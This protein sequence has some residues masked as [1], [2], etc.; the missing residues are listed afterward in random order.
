MAYENITQ[1]VE[2]L[3]LFNS[4]NRMMTYKEINML[5]DLLTDARA[6]LENL[7]RANKIQNDAINKF[8]ARRN[9]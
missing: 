6:D 4:G 8:Y 7:R 5:D 3:N 2:M 1:L 9:D